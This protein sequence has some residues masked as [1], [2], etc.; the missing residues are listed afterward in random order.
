MGFFYFLA[1]AVTMFVIL[2]FVGR[3]AMQKVTL[4]AYDIF[5]KHVQNNHLVLSKYLT[6]EDVFF[7]CM[8]LIKDQ[9]MYDEFADFLQKE[10]CDDTTKDSI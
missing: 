9:R 7:I 3:H 4:K 10:G 8:K 2:H 6:V 1:G 5:I